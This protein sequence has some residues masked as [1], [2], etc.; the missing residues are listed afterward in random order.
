MWAVR[1]SLATS[2]LRTAND[3]AKVLQAEWAA[4]FTAMRTGV[5]I[6]PKLAQL[7]AKLLASVESMLP[8]M[9]AHSSGIDAATR[10]KRISVLMWQLEDAREEQA[11][12]QTPD[13]AESWIAKEVRHRSAAADAEGLA[14]YVLYLELHLEALT[15]ASRTFPVRVQRLSARRALAASEA[16]PEAEPLTDI[17]GAGPTGT[18]RRLSHALEQWMIKP[19]PAKTVGSFSRHAAQFASLMDDPPLA[20][21]N[22]A[23]AIRFRDRLQRWAVENLKTAKTADNVLSSVKALTNVAREQGWVDGNPFERLNVEAG[24]KESEAREPWTHDELRTIF[25]DP[26]W[27]AHELPHD[28][29]AGADAAYWIPLI[30]CFS[31]ARVSEIAQLW[32]DDLVCVPGAEVLEFRDNTARVQRLKTAGAWRA[33]PMHS[34]LVRLGLCEYA[35]SLPLGSL[36]PTLPKAGDNGAGGQFS[37]WFGAY[38]LR[39]GF[40]SASKSLHSFRHLVATELRLAG[41]TDAQ[42]DAITG[43]AGQGLGRTVYAATI[44]RQAER[45]RATIELLRFPELKLLRVAE[46]PAHPHSGAVLA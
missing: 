1:R 42:A 11:R 20:S 27:R 3:L 7:R 29:K 8:N 21:L 31:G 2:D 45:L 39:K 38:K 40:K 30:A 14:A 41:A 25:D 19:R 23:L 15:D 17:Q 9:D 43:H 22:K 44:R 35:A 16:V 5:P 46:Y 37:Q 28:R 4:H 33:V 12:G 34:E 24:G 32:T 10:E 18:T 6:A 13:W 36:F 26:I